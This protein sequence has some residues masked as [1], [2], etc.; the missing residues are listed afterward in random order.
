MRRAM[1][2]AVKPI[3]AG[4]HNDADAGAVALLDGGGDLGPGRIQHR[5]QAQKGQIC[6]NRL[7]RV[8]RQI[9][10]KHT[11]G[12]GEYAQATTGGGISGGHGLGMMG[13]LEG[14]DLPVEQEACA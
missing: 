7:W 1:L 2:S 11:L 5:Q 6:L 10:G 8:G 4:D 12:H 14:A 13:L 3:V 9:S